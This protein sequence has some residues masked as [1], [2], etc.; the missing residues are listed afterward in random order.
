MKLKTFFLLFVFSMVY[1]LGCQMDTGNSLKRSFCYWK[2]NLRFNDAEM[3]MVNQLRLQHFYLRL[4][5]VEW[6]ST[7]SKAVPVGV[8][9]GAYNNKLCLESITPCVYISN[10]VMQKSSESD[11]DLIAQKT[12]QKAKSLLSD[13]E[14][15]YVNAVVESSPEWIELNKKSDNW[16]IISQLRDSIEALAHEKWRVN[17]T[18]FLIDCDWTEQSKEKYFYFL[19]SVKTDFPEM[20]IVC[21]LRLWQ[22]KY[23]EKAG[24]PPVERCL[25]MCYSV[26]NP[27]EYSQTNSI[28]SFDEIKLYLTENQYTLPLDVV[29]PIYN[30]CVIFRNKEFKGV[31]NIEN[32]NDLQADTATYKSLGTDRYF[33]KRDTVI[34][35]LYLRYGDELKVEQVSPD[36][37][38]K[39][40]ALIKENVK[41]DA[42][43]KISLFS[44]DTT[45]I[46]NYGIE[47]INR[48]FERFN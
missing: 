45:Y 10:L 25:L 30:W 31:F 43:S 17:N 4:F 22:Y 28:A 1:L 29:L 48:Y 34:G 16:N 13:L 39:I 23:T 15:N 41:L 20:K 36:E 21:T 26:G 24:I 12:V 35:S 8:L 42:E 3:K 2:T 47:K 9:T 19:N 5:D 14:N 7:I 32:L 27:R 40:V 11:L 38:E 37:L 33:F 6:S 18:E 46:K 44:W